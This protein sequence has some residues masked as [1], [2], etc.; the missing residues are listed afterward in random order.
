MHSAGV[1]RATLGRA[2]LP[3]SIFIS[4]KDAKYRTNLTFHFQITTLI[5][6]K[7]RPRK[8]E[9]TL[10]AIQRVG[11]AVSVAVGRFVAVGEAIALENHE[12]KE[13]MGH[14][15]F[16]ARRAGKFLGGGM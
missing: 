6:H 15:C 3:V 11:Q 4:V 1:A 8:S 5:N 7:E 2:F 12:L 14:A 9:R 10:A 16:E 13:E